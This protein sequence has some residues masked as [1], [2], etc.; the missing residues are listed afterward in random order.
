MIPVHYEIY[1][2]EWT[3]SPYELADK[4]S[5]EFHKRNINIGIL[6]DDIDDE[7]YLYIY[8]SDKKLYYYHDGLA[9]ITHN[10]YWTENEEVTEIE[11]G[12]EEFC[13]LIKEEK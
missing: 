1:G 12:F 3:I 5:D 6:T 13:E 7:N 8:Q 10:V 9:E 2:I 11:V 4:G